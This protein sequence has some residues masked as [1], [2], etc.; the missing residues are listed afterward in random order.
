MYKKHSKTKRL[1][2]FLTEDL[3]K[4]TDKMCQELDLSYSEVLR[5]GLKN[6]VEEWKSEKNDSK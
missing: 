3:L 2:F 4:D 6:I 5:K 1:N